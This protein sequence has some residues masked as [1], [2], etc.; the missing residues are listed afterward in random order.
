MIGGLSTRLG[1]EHGWKS[2]MANSKD[3]NAKM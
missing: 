2:C 3:W 1:W